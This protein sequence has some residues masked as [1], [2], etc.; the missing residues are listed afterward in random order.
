MDRFREK[1]NRETAEEFLRSGRFYWNSGIFAW[2]AARVLELL[3]EHQPEIRKVLS[4]LAGTWGTAGWGSALAEEFPRMPSI[5]ID[6][7]VL[8]PSAKFGTAGRGALVLPA[9]FEWDDVGSWQSLP[10]VL[11]KDA[12]GNTAHGPCCTLATNGCVIRTT[13]DHLIATIGL[14]DYVVV[15]TPDATLVAPRD[16]ENALRKLVALLEEQGFVRYL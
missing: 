10:A 5:S 15:H 9:N 4:S 8:E 7:A 2:K 6:Y 3:D 1:P 16:D 13:D 12:S 11:G 14:Q